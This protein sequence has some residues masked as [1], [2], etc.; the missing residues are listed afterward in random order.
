VKHG[1][2]SY[3]VDTTEPGQESSRQGERTG[4]GEGWYVGGA[5]QGRT[6]LLGTS[7]TLDK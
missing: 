2:G 6:P 3:V 4:Q 1:G 7:V 5:G